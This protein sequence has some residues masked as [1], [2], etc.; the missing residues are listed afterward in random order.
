PYGPPLPPYNVLFGAAYPLD[1][2]AFTRP[3]IVTRLIEKTVAPPQ[4]NEGRIAGA[5]KNGKDGKPVQGAI[6]AVH[7]RPLARVATDP[8]GTFQTV[9]LPPGPADLEISAPDFEPATVKT[10]IIVGRPM[11]LNV[12]LT[13]KPV[14]G[15]VRGKVTDK[16]G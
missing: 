11:E 14:T 15:N 1:I 2:D 12:A 7:G 6:V 5:V 10:A 3:V 13:P 16:Q 9:L 8:D 4:P